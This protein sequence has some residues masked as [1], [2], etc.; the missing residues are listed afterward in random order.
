MYDRDKLSA[1]IS[2]GSLKDIVE[3]VERSVVE[4][5][6]DRHQWNQSKVAADLGL[7]RVG[8]ANKIKRYDIQRKRRA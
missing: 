7:S 2:E 4:R 6:L 5:A 8:L 1:L 3:R